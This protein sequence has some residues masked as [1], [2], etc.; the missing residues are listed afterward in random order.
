MLYFPH[1][2]LFYKANW[3]GEGKNLKERIEYVPLRNRIASAAEGAAYIKDGMTIAM[4]GYTSSGYPKA[5]AR[6]LAKRKEAGENFKI[7]F[8]T[9]AN[10]GPLDT[11]LGNLIKRRA[12]MIESKVLSG[13]A[14]QGEICYIEQQMSKMPRL[15]Q[16]GAF[17]TI[18]IAVVEVIRITE[19]GYLVPTSSV[20]M[21]PN[22]LE[23][24]EK[25]IIEINLAQPTE[26][27]G[28]H[29]IYEVAA[30]PHRIPIPLTKVNQ[31]IG[32]PYIK[33]DL[34]KIICLVE[35]SEL[36]ETSKLAESKPEMIRIAENL[37]DFLAQEVK[38]NW[39]YLP[40]I[41]TGFG[42]LASEIVHAFEKSEFQ[43][44]TFFCGGL[45]E[46]NLDLIV[47]GKVK[48][49]STGSIQMTPAVI[50]MMHKHADI[51]RKTVVIRNGDITNNAE[52]IGRM[53]LI[54]LSTGIEM[55]IYGNVNSSHISGTK[56]VNG[57]GGGANFAQNAGLSIML[58]PSEKNNGAISNIV[59]MVSHHDICEHDIDI[60]ITENGI[61]DL[62]GKGE[63]ERAVEIIH[64]CAGSY[65]EQLK[66]YLENA[67][68]K[69][70]GHHPQILA[71]AF[72]WHTR[73]KEK[74][75][76]RI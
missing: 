27:D 43:D 29:D 57:I 25:I 12:P 7:N 62:R 13:L 73:L 2:F 34:D 55:D 58:I 3:L 39:K 21:I 40:P 74:G 48:A 9:G 23:A 44:I 68:K 71:E 72:S 5:I 52:I 36:D 51:I 42:N 66:E 28:M 10:D 53:G 1:E 17:G 61:A 56:V 15:I 31:K 46:A 38:K 50:E 32:E 20:G 30:P 49:A 16:S 11:I 8:I 14:N 19:E 26:L 76:M 63:V 54:A 4:G 45:Q 6:E 33:V 35:S 47:K 70:G 22:L 67:I 41:Q 65:Q 18:D 69:A 75:T 64:H 37:F 24:A 59:P 60:V